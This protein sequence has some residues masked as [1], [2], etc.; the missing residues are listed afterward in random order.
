M[1]YCGAGAAIEFAGDSDSELFDGTGADCIV[2]SIFPDGRKTFSRAAS[3]AFRAAN[4]RD[5]SRERVGSDPLVVDDDVARD[6]G[7]EFGGAGICGG[8]LLDTYAVITPRA[9][10]T[11]DGS[12]FA[13]LIAD[14]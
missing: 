4:L 2:D 7:V 9:A 13:G 5:D 1:R 12:G 11:N 6:G 10:A 14:L 3:A 8:G